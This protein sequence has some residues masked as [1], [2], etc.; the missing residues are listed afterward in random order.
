MHNSYLIYTAYKYTI[1]LLIIHNNM[2]IIDDFTLSLHFN[3]IPLLHYFLYHL[4]FLGGVYIILAIHYSLL[5][6][7]TYF[8]LWF[9]RVQTKTKTTLT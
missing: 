2:S 1:L 5:S 4:Y 9:V 8:I 7:V 6:R 3:I